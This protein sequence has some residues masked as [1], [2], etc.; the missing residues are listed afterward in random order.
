MKGEGRKNDVNFKRDGWT[1]TKNDENDDKTQR[2]LVVLMVDE[3][4]PP[5]HTVRMI[6]RELYC[7]SI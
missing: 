5:T 4:P 1:T 3:H 7:K 6:E 2:R